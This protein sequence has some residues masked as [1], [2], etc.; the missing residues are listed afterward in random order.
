MRRKA[1]FQQQIRDYQQLLRRESGADLTLNVFEPMDESPFSPG[2]GTPEE[3]EEENRKE[4]GPSAV[5][6][7][8][9]HG[10]EGEE[11]DRSWDAAATADAQ[12]VAETENL[13]EK[14]AAPL[15]RNN[16][17]ERR[18]EEDRMGNETLAAEKLQNQD[19]V[20]ENGELISIKMN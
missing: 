15:A 1:E 2:A 5:S 14:L 4:G 16:E 13:H 10:E 17:F 3:E 11:I 9:G 8:V 20:L 12:L 6:V 19:L 7:P 18:A